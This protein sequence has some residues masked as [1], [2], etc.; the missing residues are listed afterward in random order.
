[1]S[2]LRNDGEAVDALLLE[3]DDEP[4]RKLIDYWSASFGQTH[5]FF[6]T[7]ND[8]A[9]LRN[10]RAREPHWAGYLRAVGRLMR[11]G[12]RQ[13]LEPGLEPDMPPEQ[14]RALEALGYLD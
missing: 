4:R 6:D 1:M 14:R 12:S 3:E 5:Q 13:Q 2:D 8:P 9:E 10:L 11:R 7:T